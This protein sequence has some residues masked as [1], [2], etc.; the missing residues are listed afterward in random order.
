MRPIHVFIAFFILVCS[1]NLSFASKQVVV[2]EP[3]PAP[4]LTTVHE[5]SSSEG[6][7][8]QNP[9]IKVLSDGTGTDYVFFSYWSNQGFTIGGKEIPASDSPNFD[10]Y[11]LL[12]M[13][14]NVAN[15]KVEWFEKCERML[16]DNFIDLKNGKVQMILSF[17]LPALANSMQL[18]NLTINFPNALMY[19]YLA[20]QYD[21][22]S[23][24][25]SNAQVIT[26]ATVYNH[27]FDK[28]GNYY[29]A[30]D[31]RTG[32]AK[33]NNDIV[34]SAPGTIGLDNLFIAKFSPERTLL[35]KK[36]TTRNLEK[37]TSIYNPVFAGDEDGN[38]Y[39]AAGI[40]HVTGWL[41]IDGV[42]VQ[43]DTIK[44]K[45]DNSYTDIFLYKINANGT[46]AYG[47]TYLNS[48]NE[49]TTY[50]QSIKNN[51]LYLGGRYNG[52]MRVA[53]NDFPE[54]ARTTP[55][56]YNYFVAEVNAATGQFNWGVPFNSNTGGEFRLAID[57]NE[58]IYFATPFITN[59]IQ[60]GGKDY[61]NRT[62]TNPK[63]R[64]Y[65]IG[66]IMAG[67]TP[68]W[69][70]VLGSKTE[71]S[72]V[73]QDEQ[74]KYMYV[75]NGHL[76]TGRRR[77]NYGTNKSLE[78]GQEADPDYYFSQQD[79]V[80]DASSGELLYGISNSIRP[81]IYVSYHPLK[82]HY[83]IYSAEASPAPNIFYLNILQTE[84]FA[85]LQDNFTTSSLSIY[86]NPATDVINISG[87]VEGAVIRVFETTGRMVMNTHLINGKLDVS[88]LKNG[89]YL[90]DID[91]VRV[92]LMK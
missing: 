20:V 91:G 41:A 4:L 12:I 73:V 27:F 3:Q 24:N 36:Q 70:N 59:P 72:A 66:K 45:D 84:E 22:N 33:V 47:K 54:C 8:A 31:C 76:Y 52:K 13:K 11:N 62:I 25:W 64:N 61:Y 55:Y 86:P 63:V 18:G 60:F 28:N 32:E 10:V 29:I 87:A 7:A 75:D 43:N 48:G 39:I 77:M 83:C 23:K 14:I 34:Y 67:G 88:N 9:D 65:L 69:A 46:V 89:L 44:D 42:A 16:L 51:K 40:G 35:W 79:I 80:V 57:E 78:W 56:S 92:K 58:N 6:F 50:L 1:V 71:F 82:E 85:G 26:G 5:L 21:L 2:A 38:A 53:G 19:G 17:S 68:S 90:M 49:I 30:G 37:S 81:G 15:A 74:L